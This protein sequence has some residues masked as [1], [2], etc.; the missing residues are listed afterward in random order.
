MNSYPNMHTHSNR[1]PEIDPALWTAMLMV[2]AV[3]AAAAA[4]LAI[5]L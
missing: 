5:V 2:L 3:L 4:V 1:F